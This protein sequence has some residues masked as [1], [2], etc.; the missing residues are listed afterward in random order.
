MSRTI[1]RF[2]VVASSALRC[3]QSTKKGVVP[4]KRLL[5][6]EARQSLYNQ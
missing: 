1:G 4:L 3:I 2:L 6:F 5:H